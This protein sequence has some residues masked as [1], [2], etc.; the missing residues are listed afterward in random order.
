[1]EE[2]MNSRKVERKS[3]KR[4]NESSVSVDETKES[5]NKNI[6]KETQS[7]VSTVKKS[8]VAEVPQDPLYS[9]IKKTYSVAEDPNASEVLKSIFTT[10]PDAAKQTKAHWVTYNPFYN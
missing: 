6:K 5:I 8:N 9:K 10:H 3:K 7:K 4:K 2:N 1:M